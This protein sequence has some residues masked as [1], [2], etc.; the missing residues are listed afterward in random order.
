[1]KATLHAIRLGLGA[2]LCISLLAACDGRG[3][4]AFKSMRYDANQLA[5]HKADYL[6]KQAAAGGGDQDQ[7]VPDPNQNGGLTDPGSVPDS[8]LISPLS[9]PASAQTDGTAIST[10]PEPAGGG[11]S[12]Q[13]A[14][15]SEGAKG[16]T[17]TETAQ[18]AGTA[19]RD[20]LITTTD[21]LLAST[22]AEAAKII[23]GVTFTV[24]GADPL[25]LSVDALVS[26]NGKDQY[27]FVQNSPLTFDKQGVVTPAQTEVRQTLDGEP[28]D[29]GNSLVV[30]AFC[31]DQA[32]ATV[33]VLMDFG[34]TGGRVIAAFA[35]QKAGGAYVRVAS[36]LGDN[37]TDFDKARGAVEAGKPA[38]AEAKA[39]T[40]AAAAD[41]TATSDKT[42]TSDT[43]SKSDNAATADQRVIKEQR[44]KDDDV[45]LWPKTTSTT[46][47]QAAAKTPVKS[48]VE[49][50]KPAATNTF[51]K[52]ESTAQSAALDMALNNKVGDSKLFEASR[53]ATDIAIR[54]ATGQPL[55]DKLD[56][57]D[58]K[59]D[60]NPDSVVFLKNKATTTGTATTTATTTQK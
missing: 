18:P 58:T 11:A 54:R 50:D 10:Q 20:A 27:L 24:N 2:G 42:S 57:T 33:H 46:T 19:K 38:A 25:L 53:M 45:R 17:M 15:D 4:T 34:V 39:D 40:T 26:L 48:V 55:N 31:R 1:M 35:L 43:A 12:D 9:P 51:G 16:K 60:A 7:V 23:K 6:A 52:T 44:T 37:L 13:T 8:S 21:K 49:L 5:Q 59:S 47:T 29:M 22:D 41:T 36:N 56:L 28:Q 30:L 32:C 14:V 3:A